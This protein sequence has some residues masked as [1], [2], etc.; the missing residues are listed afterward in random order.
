MPAL[1]RPARFTRLGQLPLTYY[2]NEIVSRLRAAAFPA[3]AIAF[4]DSSGNTSEDN[5]N[6]FWDDTNNRLG[7]RTATPAASTA[8]DIGGTTGALLLPRLTTGERDALTPAN[9]MIIYNTT[10]AAIEGY[11]A[12]AWVNL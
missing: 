3:G 6:L 9:G 5:A 2:L 7:V 8:I 4:M 1:P 10:T 11:E 12:G